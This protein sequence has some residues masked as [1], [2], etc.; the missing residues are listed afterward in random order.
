VKVGYLRNFQNTDIMVLPQI[1]DWA[2]PF[3]LKLSDTTIWLVSP[4]SQ[5][6]VKAVIEGT[7]LARTDVPDANANLMQ[8]ST[9]FKSW[10][11]GVATNAVGATITL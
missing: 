2:T 7:T 3:G 8:T 11:V 9:L 6:L 1:A 5:K 10:K 4:S